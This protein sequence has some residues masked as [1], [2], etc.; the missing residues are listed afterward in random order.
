M[1]NNYDKWIGTYLNGDIAYI[2]FY[3][4]GKEIGYEEI[5][6]LSNPEVHTKRYNLI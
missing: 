6:R 4:K 5:Y 2:C 3:L 1:I